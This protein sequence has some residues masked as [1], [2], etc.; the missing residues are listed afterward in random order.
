MFWRF[1][2]VPLLALTA[3]CINVPAQAYGKTESRKPEPAK[4]GAFALSG[5][6]QLFDQLRQGLEGYSQSRLLKNFDAA[7]LPDY[8]ALQ[9]QVEVLF[10]KYESFRVR[11][12]ILQT[13]REDEQ[14]IVLADFE[15]EATP[16]GGAASGVRKSAQ[17]RLTVGWDGR[18]W[19]IT[20]FSPRDFLSF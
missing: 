2:A 7:R 6:H 19:K 3:A 16:R 12:H 5:A 9:D 15:I 4:P 13:A 10:E 1:T 11:Y 18:A 20:G 17:L 8:P 14:E